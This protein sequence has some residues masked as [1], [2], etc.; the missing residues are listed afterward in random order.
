MFFWI[1]AFAE[2]TLRVR[3]AGGKPCISLFPPENVSA[4]SAPS[5]DGSSEM[6]PSYNLAFRANP[7]PRIHGKVV[8]VQVRDRRSSF[9][10]SLL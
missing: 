8:L 9:L 2:M 7:I 5:A 1:S 4:K 3:S 10:T 6:A